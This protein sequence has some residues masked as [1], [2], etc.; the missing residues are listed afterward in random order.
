MN[1]PS[2]FTLRSIFIGIFIIS[3]LFTLNGQVK[4]PIL[5]GKEKV[6]LIA[7]QTEMKA[8]SPY[9]DMKWQYIGPTNIS[10]RCTDVE[11]VVA[12]RKKL[13]YLGR[14]SYRRCLEVDK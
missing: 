5:N 3:V 9:K 7:R 4:A 2:K 10:G 12:Q 14:I 13:Y 6:A 11:A 1:L 8:A